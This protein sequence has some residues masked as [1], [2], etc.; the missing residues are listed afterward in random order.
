MTDIMN[1]NNWFLIENEADYRLVTERYEQIKR[2][3]KEASE[4]KEKQLL[5]HLI[6][7]YENR[8]RKL[9]ELDPVEIIKI[10]MQDFGYK[11]AD[12]AAAYGDKGTVSKMLNYK[13]SLSLN[14]I[15]K[16]SELLQIPAG[17]L[18]K[19]YQLK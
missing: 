16:F 4:Y 6:A 1:R 17:L 9:A 14:M 19:E 2:V 12:L 10:R 3:T 11:P 15:R 5:V 13:Q 7:E 8:G 18:I